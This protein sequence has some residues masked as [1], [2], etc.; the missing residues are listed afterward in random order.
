MESQFKNS[1]VN[2]G[3]VPEQM[4]LKAVFEGIADMKPIAQ[5]VPSCGCTKAEWIDNKVIAYYNTGM[6]PYHLGNQ[7]EIRKTIVVHFQDE[8]TETL[9]L[10]AVI[11][12]DV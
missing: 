1:T 11:S 2:F 9:A 12:K 10:S 6:I 8:T 5:I 4:Q 7:Q 3:K